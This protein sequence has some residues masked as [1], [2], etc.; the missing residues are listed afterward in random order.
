MGSR[1]VDMIGVIHQCGPVREKNLKDGRSKEIRNVLVA[2]E[3]GLAITV[4]LWGDTANKFDLGSDEHPVIAFKRATVSEFGG[5][6]LNSNED[7]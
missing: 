6:S 5:K 4:C 3:S 1:S 2:D 7:T